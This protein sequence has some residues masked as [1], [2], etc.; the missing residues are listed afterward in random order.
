MRG[1][2]LAAVPDVWRGAVA[3]VIRFPVYQIACRV[4]DIESRDAR[5]KLIAQ[6]P[7][8]IRGLVEAEII[9]IWKIRQ[10]K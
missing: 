2:Q 4:L 10:A 1:G 6:Q 9:R 3:S 8:S 5:R 7:E